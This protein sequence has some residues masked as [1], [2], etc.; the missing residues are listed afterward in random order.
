M[1]GTTTEPD[2]VV[3]VR[4]QAE[5]LAAHDA[6]TLDDLPNSNRFK[7]RVV[8]HAAGAHV[9]LAKPFTCPVCAREARR[10]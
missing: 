4:Q 10:G 1:N 3:K 2:Y 9:G 5:A 6:G 7:L 8:C